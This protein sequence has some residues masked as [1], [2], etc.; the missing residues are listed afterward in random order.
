MKW[1]PIRTFLFSALCLGFSAPAHAGENGPETKTGNVIF[2][3]PDGAG[4]NHWNALRLLNPGPDGA[5]NWDKL[6]AMAVYKGH[7]EDSVTATSHGGATVHAYGVKVKAD[8]FGLNGSA[9][10][11]AASGQRM[12]IVREAKAA[13]KAVGLVQTGHI[14]EPGTAAFVASVQSRRAVCEIAKQVVESG[15]DVIMAGGEKYLLPIGVMGRHGP[16]ACIE[17]L[18][19]K[20]TAAGY[21]IVYSR[22]ELGVLQARNFEGVTKLLG[23]FA[24]NNTFND[25]SEEDNR[26]AHLPHYN[27][28]APSIAEMSAAALAILS[29]SPSGFLL[30]AEEEG[31]DNMA[32]KNN[33]PGQLEALRRADE[34]IAVFAGFLE[35]APDTLLLM[36]ADSEAGGMTAMGYYRLSLADPLPPS[37]RNGAPYD[38]VGGTGTPPFEAAP[39]A[40]GRRFPFGISWSTLHDTSGAILVRGAGLN[41]ELIRGTLDNTEMYRLMYLTL[42]GVDVRKTQ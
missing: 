21:T 15:V 22:G 24:H 2:F 19:E 41:S 9:E 25:A 33:A 30:V 34:A 37:D 10:I 12:S 4:L 36:A 31:T 14:A 11:T 28:A 40:Q 3:H 35:A 5:L 8:S 20:A 42:F 39:D 17:N 13:G 38:G 16:G 1:K 23:V 26:A 27:P 6:P 32:N 29:R 18:I 7:M